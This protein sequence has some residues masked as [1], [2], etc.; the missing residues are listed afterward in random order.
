MEAAFL[1]EFCISFIIQATRYQGATADPY[2]YLYPL[3]S[4]GK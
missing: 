2:T 1:S 4:A 3:E